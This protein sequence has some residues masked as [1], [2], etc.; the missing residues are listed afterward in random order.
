M[1]FSILKNKTIMN[2]VLGLFFVIGLIAFFAEMSVLLNLNKYQSFIKEF[3]AEGKKPKNERNFSG[4]QM[5]FAIMVLGYAGWAL[6]G[7][8]T[9]QWPIFV[10]LLGLSII[11]GIKGITK[12]KFVKAL[13][14]FLSASLIFFA[15]MNHFF[16]HIDLIMALG[17]GM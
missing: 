5:F 13:D 4:M 2:I 16:F 7:L 9:P 11:F 6:L 1:T 10:A 17:L 12:Y 15:I 3:R 8:L 14:S